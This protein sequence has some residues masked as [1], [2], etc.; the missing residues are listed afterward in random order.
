MKGI[1][2]EEPEVLGEFAYFRSGA[3][4]GQ[5]KG[6]GGWKLFLGQP[7]RAYSLTLQYGDEYSWMTWYLRLWEAMRQI[8]G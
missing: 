7:F 5:V 3:A 8:E 4:K 6:S 1:F 2:R